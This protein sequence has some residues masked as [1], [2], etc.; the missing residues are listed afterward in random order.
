M[1]TYR[2]RLLDYNEYSQETTFGT[3]EICMYTGIAENPTFTFV[4]TDTETGE[5]T[6]SN[7]EG[8]NWDWGDYSTV[9][10][11]N[12]ALFGDWLEDNTVTVDTNEMDFGD[13]RDL[14]DRFA[15]RQYMDA[16]GAQE[17]G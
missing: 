9:D 3:C 15:I 11:S 10:I 17:N 7:V 4:F 1:N 2:V 12:V 6:L 13:I 8:Y 16:R 5:E 14:A